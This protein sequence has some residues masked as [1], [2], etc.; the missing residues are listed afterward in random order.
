MTGVEVTLCR[1]IASCRTSSTL[2]GRQIERHG[3]RNRRYLRPRCSAYPVSD[4]YRNPQAHGSTGD[5]PA[6]LP[7]GTS[8][9]GTFFWVR[10]GFALEVASNRARWTPSNASPAGDLGLR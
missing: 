5:L 8:P 6:A 9:V 3:A 4:L 10:L 7:T 1:S 2:R